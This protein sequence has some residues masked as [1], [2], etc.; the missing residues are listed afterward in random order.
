MCIYSVYNMCIT[1]EEFESCC[2]CSP[3]TCTDD[4]R[5]FQELLKK[6]ENPRI[7]NAAKE[8]Y[9]ARERLEIGNMLGKGDHDVYSSG[10]LET[11]MLKVVCI[12]SS[13]CGHQFKG[14]Y[15]CSVIQWC[16]VISVLMSVLCL[17]CF[18]SPAISRQRRHCVL[19]SSV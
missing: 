12:G 14:R 10:C 11:C 19:Q 4:A 15:Y 3:L 18:Y 7:R 8:V 5:Y 9:I 13:L 16:S 17:A 2:N 1:S 6:I